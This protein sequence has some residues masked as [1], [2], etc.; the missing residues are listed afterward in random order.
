MARKVKSPPAAGPRLVDQAYEV[1]PIDSVFPHPR[2]VN[3]GCV[4]AIAESMRVHGFYGALRVQRSSGYIVAGNHSWRAAKEIGIELVPVIMLDVSDDTALRLMLIDNATAR[5]SHNRE[6][7]LANL[8]IDIQKTPSALFGTVFD[9]KGLDDLLA[10]LG[11]STP[12]MDDETPEFAKEEPEPAKEKVA[13][14]RG[15]EFR[16]VVDCHSELH[17]TELLDR[18]ESED[19]KCRPLIS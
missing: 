8:L 6:Q 2:N 4:P 12:R 7:E 11:K 18:F 10:S 19:L 15:L 17:Q 5:A 14:S 16:I 1:V 13:G 9:G 3:E